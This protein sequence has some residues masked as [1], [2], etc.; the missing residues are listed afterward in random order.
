M[1]SVVGNRQNPQQGPSSQPAGPVLPPPAGETPFLFGGDNKSNWDRLALTADWY[2]GSG[3]YHPVSQATGHSLPGLADLTQGPGGP[4]PYGQHP[5]SSHSA[6][7]S[8]PGIGQAMQH[9]S[10]QLNRD[11]ERDSR[12][13]EMLER[14][15]QEEMAREQQRER[16]REQVERQ[17]L[18]RQ[19]REQQHHPVQS[20][21]GSIPIHQPVASKVPNSIHGPNGLLSNL[22]GSAPPGAP[23]NPMQSS[24]AGALYAQI[25]HGEG[26]PR[27]Y[28]QHSQGPPGQP[29][30]GYNGSAAASLAVGVAVVAQGQ[31][32]ILN[33]SRS[34]VFGP[35]RPF[36]PLLLV[37]LKRN[38]FVSNSS[39]CSLMR[40]GP[41]PYCSANEQREIALF[42][43]Q[44]RFRGD[45]YLYPL[46][47]PLYHSSPWGPL[48]FWVPSRFVQGDAETD[49]P[50]LF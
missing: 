23:Q 42:P 13:R 26:T 49:N 33:V 2:S 38:H 27:P 19:Q 20:H 32:P 35:P 12:E 47:L 36:R 10:P 5:Q 37:P 9:P 21:P 41:L 50:A 17:Q 44:R 14:H 11:H 22:G 7:H 30:L 24:G 48:C 43:H 28:M 46:S 25:Q 15:R 45:S 34:H 6:G 16:E 31:Q 8:L 4:P 18:E 1:K 29:M 39:P 3:P 40:R